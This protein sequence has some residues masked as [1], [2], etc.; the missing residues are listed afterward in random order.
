VTTIAF[1]VP[2]VWLAWL[3][4]TEWVPMFPL[5]DLESSTVRERALLALANYPLPLLIADQL[6]S[7]A[8]GVQA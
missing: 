8:R 4:L 2:L 7:A 6:Q 3:I 1:L 5:N